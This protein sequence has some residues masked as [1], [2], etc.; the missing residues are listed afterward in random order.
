MN[1]K[2]LIICPY[3][4]GVQAGQRLKYEPHINAIKNKGYEVT[5]SSF[6]HPNMWKVLYTKGYILKKIFYTFVGYMKR[7]NQIFFLNKYDII[8]IFLWVTPFGGNFFEK[9]YKLFSKKI[10]YDIEDNI[11]QNDDNEN[12]I[13]YNLR[14]SKKIEYLIKNS[15]KIVCSSPA[16]MK[17]CNLLS[18]KNNCYYIPPSLN[19]DRYTVK[20]NY[21]SDILT[22]G[23]TGTFSSK[24][25]LDIVMPSILK[26]S[27]IRN[28]KFK[29]ISN[30][31]FEYD[32]LN[33]ESIKWNK[34][35]EIDELKK[36]DI[37]IYPLM[38][39]EWISGKSG[40]K[41][42]QYMALG[43]PSVSSKFGN[44]LNFINNNK[45]GIL[46]K[47]NNEDWFN[48]LLYL[49]D[50]ADIRKKIGISGRKTIE[51]NFSFIEI[52]KLYL[53]ILDISE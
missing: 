33:V 4:Y 16:L 21:S 32:N 20:N 51:K 12:K 45:N 24:K 18:N 47:N 14:S 26:L 3:P 22:I 10:I 38:N 46:V 19:L 42:M 2:I 53:K 34:N 29:I 31:D 44:V 11:L 23:W 30:F 25:Y 50:N 17:K 9:I 5:I 28:F 48:A 15:N 6:I 27:K 1:K 35:N 39:D 40:L 13:N 52:Q 8:Y 41:A 49:L 36:I 43:I 37:G 7:F